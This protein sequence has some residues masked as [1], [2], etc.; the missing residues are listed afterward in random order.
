MKEWFSKNPTFISLTPRGRGALC[1][2]CKN[3]NQ[4]LLYKAASDRAKILSY[5]PF[6][7]S[8]MVKFRR[9]AGIF[10]VHENWIDE[11]VAFRNSVSLMKKS[12]KEFQNGI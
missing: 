2:R 10:S 8:Y 11:S 9:L 4:T 5:N 12:L 7:Q 1:Q 6:T 3:T